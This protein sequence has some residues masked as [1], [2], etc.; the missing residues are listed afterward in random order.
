MMSKKRILFIVNPISGNRNKRRFPDIAA[1][2]LGDD[3]SY[4]IV[5][6]ESVGHATKLATEAV[7]DYDIV[8]AVGGDGTLNE[9]A[10]GLIGTD[11]P[12]AIIPSGSGNGLARCLGIPLHVDKAL[13]LLSQGSVKSIDTASVNGKP[14][15]SVAGIGLDAQTAYDFAADPRRGFLTYARY[16]VRNYLHY[17]PEEVRITLE[18]RETVVCSPLLVT[19]ANSN[20]FGYHAIIAPHASLQ[21]G[22]LDTC[23]LYR[24][25]LLKAPAAVIKMMLGRLNKSRLHTDYQAAHIHLERPAPGVVNVD[26]EPVMMTETLDIRIVP[27]SLR[28]VCPDK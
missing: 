19:F 21:D 26:G 24:P 5:F 27:K 13:R 22:L 7:G 4:E 2:V 8:A 18:D 10:R 6:T 17:K 16:A 1:S 20:Q 15:L 14:F 11:T 25:S 28:V 9:V 12:L 23:V 3:M